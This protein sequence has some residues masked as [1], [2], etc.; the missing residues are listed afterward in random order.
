M[1]QRGERTRTQNLFTKILDISSKRSK[2]ECTTIICFQYEKIERKGVIHYRDRRYVFVPTYSS[3]FKYVSSTKKLDNK[4]EK[5][6][7][8][9]ITPKRILKRRIIEMRF[10]LA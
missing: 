2:S 4:K 1:K 10:I 3:S 8:S 9:R 7:Q 5:E 6:K